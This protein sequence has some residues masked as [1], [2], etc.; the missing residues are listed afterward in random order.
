VDFNLFQWLLVFL[1]ASALLTLFPLFSARNTPIHVR[2]ALGATAALLIAPN[3]PDLPAAAPADLLDLIGLFM[4]EIGAGL[5][6]GFVSRMI[7]YA[8]DFAGGLM[9]AEIGLL[10]SPDP[11][12]FS[13]TESQAPGLIMYYLA[14]MLMLS[15]DLHHWLLI[16]FQRSYV[17]LPPGAAH[18]QQALLL[19]VI[20]DSAL[21]FRIALQIAAPVVAV[22]FI[23]T[24]LFSVLGRAVPQMNVFSESFAIRALAG[25]SVFGLTVNLMAS[26][27]SNYLRRLPDDLLLVAQMMGV[28]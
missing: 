27:I 11:D 9:S 28:G 23:I 24:M 19:Q 12:P 5:L 8:L 13:S 10:F 17:V 20:K 22:S 1:R 21:V 2:I 7:F 3:L 15:L 4:K 16:A 14:A 26:H 6:I 18:L 25:L